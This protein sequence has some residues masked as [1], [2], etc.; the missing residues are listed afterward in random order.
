M[1]FS[2]TVHE[3]R[4]KTSRGRKVGRQMIQAFYICKLE[5]PSWMR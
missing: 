5:V 3:L 2:A 1:E 4:P